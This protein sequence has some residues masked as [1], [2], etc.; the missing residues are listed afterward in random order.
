VEGGASLVIAEATWTRRRG[1]PVLVSADGRV[2]RDGNLVFQLDAAGRVF[3]EDHEPVAVV[4]PGGHLFGT[5]DELLGRIGLR[6]AS[7]PWSSIAWLRLGKDGTLV[8]F[9]PDGRPNYGGSWSGCHGAAV[10]AC[11]VVSHLMVLEALQRRLAN[12]PY[13]PLFI[14]VGAGVWY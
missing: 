6:N 3:D 8:L 1:A 2:T 14:G 13:S 5:N 9:D 11:T 12:A 4:A 10:R 7:P